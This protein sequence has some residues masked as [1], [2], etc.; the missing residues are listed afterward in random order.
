MQDSPHRFGAWQR[1]PALWFTPP[2]TPRRKLLRLALALPLLAAAAPAPDA[3]AFIRAAGNE[4][5]AIV[6]HPAS[7]T[8]RRA[9]LGAFLDRVVD[10]P[11]VARF[12]L[13]R[14]WRRATPAQ[15]ANYLALFRDILVTSVL[16]RVGAYRHPAANGFHVRILR[17]VPNGDVTDV[18]TEVV[19]P[20]S[21]AARVTWVVRQEPAG[22]RI[23][24][25]IAEGTSLRITVRADYT[26]FLDQHR[27]SIPTL[28]AAMARQAGTP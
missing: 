27:G 24:D 15:Q 17:P 26:S 16:A 20:G 6:S 11:Y 23:I 1:A 2:M 14:F 19:R 25:L 10:I 5:A 9:A 13:G 28:L 12:C 22:P 21:P 3:A 18:T 8:Q 7:R 4:L